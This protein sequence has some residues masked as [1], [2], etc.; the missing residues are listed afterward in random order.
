MER[1]GMAWTC[2]VRAGIRVALLALGIGGA[3]GSGAFNLAPETTDP[4]L[5]DWTRV[6]QAVNAAG[7]AA[8]TTYIKHFRE[9][10]HEEITHLAYGCELGPT[11]C[12]RD[13]AGA[14]RHVIDGVR[15]NDNPPFRLT[16]DQGKIAFGCLFRGVIQ[17]PNLAP[18]CWGWVFGT[19]ARQAAPPDDHVVFGPA[20]PI[21][22]RSHFGDMQF[23]HAMAVDGDRAGET[24]SKIMA[25]AQFTHAVARG[26]IAPDVI[27]SSD[28]AGPA[29][30]FFPETI[31]AF[32]SLTVRS[33][34]VLGAADQS[35][36]RVRDVAFG[37]L[38]HMVEDSF[39]NAHVTRTALPAGAAAWPPG[40]V[41]RFLAYAHQDHEK[42]SE[43]DAL[44]AFRAPGTRPF[45]TAAVKRVVQARAGD[46]QT[47][48]GIL[49]DIF[50]PSD[51]GAVAGPG[52]LKASP[53]VIRNQ[54]A[55]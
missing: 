16:L 54:K 22:Q 18:D 1:N 39:S 32:K 30:R 45:A 34:F 8:V 6:F 37:S 44:A 23:L 48:Q 14:P 28:V 40:S 51:E 26:D 7:G 20:D 10:V 29:A 25:W 47:M 4:S 52:H 19:A 13:G 43:E 46:W 42:H 2:L 36:Q 55:P 5:D 11:T 12:E 9:P 27:V 41:A 35:D 15:W 3:T 38:L 50:R 24:Y 53:V 17:L 21:L 33:L 49:Q 31:T